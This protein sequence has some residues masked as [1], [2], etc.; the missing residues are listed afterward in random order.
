[1]DGVAIALG[2]TP[3]AARSHLKKVFDKADPHRQAEL[4]WLLARLSGWATRAQTRCGRAR[5]GP[6]S[7]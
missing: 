6:C 7:R 5:E 1:V 4:A 3:N 2:M